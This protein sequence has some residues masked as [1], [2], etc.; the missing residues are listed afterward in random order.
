MPQNN[1]NLLSVIFTGV[2]DSDGFDSAI[3][4]LNYLVVHH[5]IQNNGTCCYVFQGIDASIANNFIVNF[6]KDNDFSEVE[7]VICVGN[8]FQR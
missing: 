3:H 7:F 8:V 6:L 1:N 2:K 4:D 5:L